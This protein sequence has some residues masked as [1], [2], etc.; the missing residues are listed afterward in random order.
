MGRRVGW[1]EDRGG[2]GEK[3]LKTAAAMTEADAM[4]SQQINQQKV[5]G[6]GERGRGKEGEGWE[7]GRGWEGREDTQG[8]SS[9]D[10]GRHSA[11][12]ADKPAE[13]V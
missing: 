1:E 7:E 8:S 2:R 11:V 12:T 5:C 3:T 9:D 13:G 6:R 10:R 4:L